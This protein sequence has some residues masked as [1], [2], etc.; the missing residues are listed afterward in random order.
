M[1]SSEAIRRKSFAVHTWIAEELMARGITLGEVKTNAPIKPLRR[2]VIIRAYI[3]R[4]RSITESNRQNKH[5]RVWMRP[6]QEQEREIHMS[7]VEGD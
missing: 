4:P 3:F 1:V 7:I 2:R 5:T 6:K